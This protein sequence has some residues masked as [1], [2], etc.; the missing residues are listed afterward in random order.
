[1]ERAV[2]AAAFLAPCALILLG[3][4]QDA[5]P[6]GLHAAMNALAFLICTPR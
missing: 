2:L 5:T 1:M 6:L 4:V 3:C